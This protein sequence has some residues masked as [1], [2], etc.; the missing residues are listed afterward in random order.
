MLTY[1]RASK[2]V[3]VSCVALLA[4][5]AAVAQEARRRFDHLCLMRQQKFD[6]ILPE[7]M[8]ENHID[9][10]I[11]AEREGHY[12]PMVDQLGPGYANEIGYYIFT[13]RGTG[14]IERATLNLVDADSDP[15]SD[16]KTYDIDATG[17]DL[18]KFVAER[19]P[20][21]IGID[22]ATE[23]GTADGLS[24]SLH[25]DLVRK[26]GPELAARLVSAEKLVSDFR[27]RHVEAELVAFATAGEY[28]RLFAERALSNEV[29]TPGKTSLNDVAWWMRE[30]LFDNHLESSFGTP[31]VYVLGPDRG[32]PV[33]N[34]HII[35]PGELLAID[36]GVKYQGMYTD[37][38]RLAYVLKPG[39]AVPPPGVQHAFD[40]AMAVRDM[41]YRTVKPGITAGEALRTLNDKV[42]AMPGYFVDAKWPG[43]TPQG[44]AGLNPDPR[45]DRHLHRESLHGGL[46][47][48]FRTVDGGFQP[49]AHDLPVAPDQSVLGRVLL[50]H[51]DTGV[52]QPQGDHSPRGR[53]GTHGARTRMGLSAE[54]S[55]PADSLTG[56]RIPC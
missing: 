4:A 3:L 32:H 7:V 16:C 46:W 2:S 54:L 53:R 55:H 10:W 26:L 25:E 12:D 29:I 18:K 49:A 6:R 22:I 31:S 21:R 35:Q 15:D 20:K 42:R 9:M 1:T 33:S 27:S 14:R 19:N 5:T 24:Y 41:I 43:Y 37:M 30:R 56:H 51:R 38:K 45:C 13:D 8:R 17:T 11:V 44:R 47:P 52:G 36:W 48:R 39:E 23:I 34:D 28:S 50:L 40:K